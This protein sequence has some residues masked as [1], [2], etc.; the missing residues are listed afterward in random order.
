ML[1]WVVLSDQPVAPL[2]FRVRDV[3]PKPS[4]PES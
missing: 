4:T 1:H 2:G 3:N